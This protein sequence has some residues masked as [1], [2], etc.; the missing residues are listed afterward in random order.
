M[1]DLELGIGLP[2]L[3]SVAESAQR[4]ESLGYDFIST[5]EHVF[6]YGPIGNGLISLAAAAGVAHAEPEA[7]EG[8]EVLFNGKDLTGW[9]VDVP[10]KDNKPD[11]KDT[12]IVREGLLVSLGQPRG[13]FDGG[14]GLET[15]QAL[16]GGPGQG[17]VTGEQVEL[18]QAHQV[19]LRSSA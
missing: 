2:R 13:R 3:D 6:F 8:F 12:F 11:L 15:P 16:E 19:P 17:Q 4:A 9:H 5:G 1:T 18:R 7:P 10:A 14:Q